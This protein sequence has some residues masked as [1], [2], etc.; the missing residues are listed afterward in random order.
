MSAEG[1]TGSYGVPTLPKIPFIRGEILM[2]EGL[3]A[4]NVDLQSS[5]TI[6][7]ESSAD[8]WVGV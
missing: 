7:L 8:A 6:A 3:L 2:T 1:S 4:N 5:S